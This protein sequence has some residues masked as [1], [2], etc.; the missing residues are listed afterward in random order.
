MCGILRNR[1]VSH[2]IAFCR[3][4]PL[5][6]NKIVVFFKILTLPIWFQHDPE[7]PRLRRAV[8]KVPSSP[9]LSEVEGKAANR[10]GHPEG[11]DHC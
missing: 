8:Q 4:Y 6:Y 1:L 2:K 3:R 5:I 9:A 10:L 11:G 7:I